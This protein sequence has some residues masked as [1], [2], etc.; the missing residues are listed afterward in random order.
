MNPLGVVLNDATMKSEWLSHTLWSVYCVDSPRFAVV[1]PICRDVYLIYGFRIAF[2]F[3]AFKIAMVLDFYVITPVKYQR[4][5]L[6]AKSILRDILLT[7]P[8]LNTKCLH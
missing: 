7:E 2:F 4:T 3:I 8:Y 5:F 1:S 6:F